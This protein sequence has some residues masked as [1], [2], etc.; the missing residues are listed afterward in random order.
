MTD[1]GLARGDS[2]CSELDADDQGAEREESKVEPELLVAEQGPGAPPRER[3]VH[4]GEVRAGD[5][6]ERDDH[7]L[8][9]G[10][11]GLDRAGLRREASCGHRREGVR[12]GLE[13]AHP[14]V[15][16]R[17]AEQREHEDLQAGQ[18][19]VE[20]PETARGV[21]DRG[22]QLL[23]LGPGQLG[24]HQLPPSDPQT[25]ENGDRQHDDP[26]AA[27]PLRELA[28][29][30]E[31]VRERLDVG[32]HRRAGRREPRHRL[33]VGVDRIRGR[34]LAGEEVRKRGEEGGEEPCERDDQ[35]AFARAHALLPL[36]HALEAEA[37]GGSQESRPHERPDRL[38]IA[39]R[40]RGRYEERGAQV[41]EQRADEVEGSAD[42]DAERVEP[43]AAG[44][45]H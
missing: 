7:P 14:L 32:D 18:A 6:H 20:E 30:C 40:D 2:L 36:R 23:E 8:R 17:P 16:A 29:E 22:G 37:G 10:G 31:R 9:G 1:R 26:H 42:V 44:G 24:L 11:E 41:A 19:D 28:P 33:E 38:S 12:D 35:E 21:P 13:E 27:E 25:R 39:E 15:D 45:E 4:E 34:A 3:A 5:D 43:D